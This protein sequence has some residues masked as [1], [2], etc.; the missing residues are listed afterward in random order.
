MESE[1]IPIHSVQQGSGAPVIL[2]HG[3][4]ASLRQWETLMPELALA[5]YQAIALDLPGH[6][7]SA[8]PEAIGAYHIESIL[9]RFSTWIDAL[10]LSQPAVLVAHSLGGYLALR[11]ALAWPQQVRALV[12]VNPYY[13][14]RQLSPWIRR[15]TRH[16]E[17]GIK[18]VQAMPRELLDRIFDQAERVRSDLPP[19]LLRQ[20][21][22][23]YRHTS[24]LMLTTL[25]TTRNLTAQL[26]Q[27]RQPVRVIWGGRDQTL[28][29]ASF[30]LLHKILPNA[31][32]FYF[33]RCGHIPHL[34]QAGQFN[35]FVLEFL[36]SLRE[37]PR[38]TQAR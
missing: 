1:P 25:C 3:M 28:A 6:G 30:A 23:D 10:N 22:H 7:R 36:E 9:A 21:M 27:I 37:F 33:D 35:Q 19:A 5:G 15:A 14:P 16:P 32:G 17:T 29:P 4:A 11:F 12:L 18:L 34:T 24:P 2:V 26:L 31:R 20:L 13:R 8:R 38:A